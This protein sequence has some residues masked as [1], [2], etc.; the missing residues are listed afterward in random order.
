MAL[1][2][3][4]GFGRDE[5]AYGLTRWHWEVRSV[6]GRGLDVRFRLPGGYDG[7]EPRLRETVNRTVVRG[8][9][10][11]TLTVQRDAGHSEFRINEDALASAVKAIARVKAATDCDRARPEGILALRGVLEVVE[12]SE[13]EAEA[14]QRIAEM[15][16][17]F[18]RALLRLV[19]ARAEEG[20]RLGAVLLDQVATVERIA[21]SVSVAPGRTPEAIRARL[22]EQVRRVVEA[23]GSIDA[24]R[25]HQ[26]AA[27]IATRIDV[28]EE[29]KRL[30]A[31][32]A[33]A[34]DLIASAG[35]VGRKLDFL[36]QE[37]NREAN[38]LCSK[39]NDVE[40]TRLGLD[41][42]SV[43]DQMREQVQNIE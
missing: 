10:T 15:M 13:N 40:V 25:L 3:M 23:H 8:S 6:N 41:L 14:E 24:E 1:K 19:A 5:G 20:E 37:F 12:A 4:T 21:A 32:V 30:D 27:L 26:E 11:A 28:D 7:L 2:S 17:T 33:Q 18:E 29:L 22:A 43:I 38:T 9:V 36:T 34:R 31:H 39:A 35:P 42:K 16:V